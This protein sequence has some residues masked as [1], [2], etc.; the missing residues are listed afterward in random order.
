MSRTQLKAL[1]KR[2][3]GTRP[4]PLAKLTD[5]DL[6]VAI[7]SITAGEPVPEDIAE[8]IDDALLCLPRDPALARLSNEQLALA[9]ESYRDH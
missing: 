4:A 7:T 1:E 3:Y 9:I 6:T 2:M 8:R 5:E